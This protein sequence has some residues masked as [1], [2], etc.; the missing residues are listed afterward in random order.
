M[1]TRLLAPA[2]LAFGRGPFAAPTVPIARDITSRG[3][4]VY[5]SRLKVGF[6]AA[7]H[8][9]DPFAGVLSPLVE[10]PSGAVLNWSRC[11]VVAGFRVEAAGE[12]AKCRGVRGV[13][14]DP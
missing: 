14:A 13:A 1:N 9:R 6:S 7:P 4:R 5:I 2:L 11:D 8:R 10:E 12:P 3:F